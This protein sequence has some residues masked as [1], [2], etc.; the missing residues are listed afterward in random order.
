MKYHDCSGQWHKQGSIHKQHLYYY[1]MQ[2]NTTE[3]PY[4]VDIHNFKLE[5]ISTTLFSELD[6]QQKVSTWSQC[7]P[8]IFF[9]F[10]CYIHV[11]KK[12]C[13]TLQRSGN[14]R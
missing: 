9:A 10:T 2:N 1:Y 12:I 3:L 5:L 13:H 11:K 8:F 4:I 14:L 6:H 7:L